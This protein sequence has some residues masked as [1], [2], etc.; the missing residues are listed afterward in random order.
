MILL[1]E[2]KKLVLEI[3]RRKQFDFLYNNSS[4]YKSLV[5]HRNAGKTWAAID[6]L[7]LHLLEGRQGGSGMFLTKS[8]KQAKGTVDPAMIRWKAGLG[9]LL[10]YNG[11]DLVYK[12]RLSRH[13]VRE[14]FLFSYDNPEAKRGF[15][16][17]YIVCDEVA[18]MSKAMLNQI[19]MPM[20]GAAMQA[21]IGRFLAIGTPKGPNLFYEL[22]LRGDDP[23]PAWKDWSSFSLKASESG[24]IDRETL[25]MIRQTMSNAEYAQEMECDFNANVLVGSVFG[26]FMDKFTMKNISDSYGYDPTI[27]VYT[28]WD[29][30]HA[31]FT[32]IWFFQIKNDQIT[33]IDFLEDNQRGLSYYANEV[34]CK[35]YIYKKHFVPHDAEHQNI[36]AEQTIRQ[37]LAAQ[38]LKGLETLPRASV[39]SGIETARM[40]LKAAR[41]SKQNCEEGLVHLKA[42][43]YKYDSNFGVDRQKPFKDEHE[44]AADAFRYACV[45]IQSLKKNEGYGIIKPI[46]SNGGGY[47]P[48]AV[49]F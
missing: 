9:K 20:L 17:D 14:F 23:D 37:Q 4:P 47:N 15:H 6:W 16:P 43:R 12:I 30:G 26:E 29:F 36:R 42:Y 24:L 1:P 49:N 13:D 2:K 48:L 5:A 25:N 22:F 8:L 40:T 33:F 27:P 28:A 7:M 39:A 41:F 38:G 46:R 44:D 18:D 19:I 3:E 10:S 31:H 35:P 21:R 32:S 11:T 45:A 34:L